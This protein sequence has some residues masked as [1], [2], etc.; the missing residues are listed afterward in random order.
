MFMIC[1]YF[2]T[3]YFQESWIFFIVLMALCS[4]KS[5]HSSFFIFSL[6]SLIE[7]VINPLFY[8]H[9]PSFLFL[10]Y[11]FFSPY[12]YSPPLS[13][14]LSCPLPSHS[15]F[16]SPPLFPHS[17]SLPLLSSPAPSPPFFYFLQYIF[18]WANL[19]ACWAEYCSNKIRES[20]RF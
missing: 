4:L 2:V 18:S 15:P 1:H 11:I 16:L 6:F 14:L 5:L 3:Y 9:L 19:I 10:E 8:C 12:P 17:S 20:K 13:S 7:S